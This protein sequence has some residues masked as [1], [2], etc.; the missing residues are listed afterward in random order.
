MD[1][2]SKTNPGLTASPSSGPN[3]LDLDAHAVESP[4]DPTLPGSMGGAPSITPIPLSPLSQGNAA[5]QSRGLTLL[6]GL[7]SHE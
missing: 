2:T 5:G 6:Y 1:E 4:T 3:P 7:I